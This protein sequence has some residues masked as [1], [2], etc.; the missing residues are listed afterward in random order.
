MSD[1][2]CNYSTAFCKNHNTQ[3]ALRNMIENWKRN[4]NKED[5]I[6]AIFMDLCKAFNSLDHSL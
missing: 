4:L 1:K 5:K 6:E 2:F 3:Y